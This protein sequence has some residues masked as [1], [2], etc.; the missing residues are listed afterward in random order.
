MPLL[1]TLLSWSGDGDGT[2]GAQPH[3]VALGVA[4][5]V[6]ATPLLLAFTWIE[7]SRCGL[8]PG[9]HK[10]A[11]KKGSLKLTIH[12]SG[13]SSLLRGRLLQHFYLLE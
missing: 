7:G 13:I 8:V 10:H 3:A 2:E 9:R 6:R 11:F 4:R 12:V 1:W 5:P